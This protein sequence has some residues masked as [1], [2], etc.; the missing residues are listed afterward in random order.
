M[1]I[2]AKNRRARY[3]Y[4][5]LKKYEAG[6]ALRGYE[7]KSIKT[8]HVSLKE[9]YV[10]ALDNELFLTNATIPLYKFAGD[11]PAY[12][13][14]APR[15]LLLHKKEISYLIGKLKTK[16]LTLVPLSMY[17]KKGKIKL[18]FALARGKRKYDKRQTIK[19]R[20]DKMRT[21]RYLK[22]Y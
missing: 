5:I 10:T 22:Q 19:E 3:N 20:E 15:K 12:N 11:R 4:D 8:G 14:T 9:S 13:A 7:V 6:I 1:K 18:L 2:F 16:G 21:Q 17:N